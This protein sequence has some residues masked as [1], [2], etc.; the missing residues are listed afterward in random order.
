MII[1]NVT[2]HIEHSIH[3]AW[4][5]WMKETHLPEVMQTGCFVK[6]QLVKIMDTDETEGV[7]YAAQYYAES[8]AA[9]N[10]YIELYAPALRQSGIDKWGNKIIAFRSLMEVVH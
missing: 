5:A 2:T 1:Y 4:L 9:Y 10:R 6:F 7:T 8:K 3:E